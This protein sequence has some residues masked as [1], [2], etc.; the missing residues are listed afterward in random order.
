VAAAAS[1]IDLPQADVGDLFL[2][3]TASVFDLTLVT[4][5]AQLLECSWLNTMDNR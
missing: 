3:A 1:K 4:S 5:D 2:A